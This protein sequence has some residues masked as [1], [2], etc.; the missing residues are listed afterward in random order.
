MEH[1][2]VFAHLVLLR[3]DIKKSPLMLIFL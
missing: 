3:V 2:P 1:N